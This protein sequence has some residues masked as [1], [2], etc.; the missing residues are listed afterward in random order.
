MRKISYKTK[1]KQHRGEGRGN[2]YKPYIMASE[3]NSSG[4]C[5]NPIDWKTGRNLELLSQNELI[6]FYTLRWDDNVFEI[7]EQFPLDMNSIW[8]I[9]DAK[10]I[11]C[12][13]N[14]EHT[15]TT[16]FLVTLVNGSE[17]AYSVKNDR[18]V[19][20]NP[21]TVEKLYL[22]KKYWEQKGVSYQILFA[23]ELNMTLVSNLRLVMEYYDV[24]R[25]YDAVSLLKH[26]IATKQIVVN[27]ED[28][29]LDFVELKSLIKTLEED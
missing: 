7:R 6:V 29:R 14:I 25:V 17:K 20:N 4:T 19:L 10:G 12:S 1:Q 24:N 21:K 3:F 28:K 8:H 26:K 23:R 18:T 5:A 2:Q 13:R 22:E 11:K 27:L 9:A 15:M 16:D